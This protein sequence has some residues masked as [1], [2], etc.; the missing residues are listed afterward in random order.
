MKIDAPSTTLYQNQKEMP[1]AL[2]HVLMEVSVV[3][4]ENPSPERQSTTDLGGQDRVCGKE[5]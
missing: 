5:Q 3:T 4:H 1:D 2:G